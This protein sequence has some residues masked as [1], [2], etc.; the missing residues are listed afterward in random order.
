MNR[1]FTYNP[2]LSLTN[3]FSR[4]N[5]FT[6]LPDFSRLNRFSL[7]NR[8]Y[9]YIQVFIGEKPVYTLKTGLHVGNRIISEKP[10]FR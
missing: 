8:V 3:W 10:D 6:Y 7:I 5:R 1:A 2:V 9:T 4:I